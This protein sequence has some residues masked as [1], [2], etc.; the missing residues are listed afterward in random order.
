MVVQK[1][2]VC[3]E[4]CAVNLRKDVNYFDKKS[5]GSVVQWCVDLLHRGKLLYC[6]T[7]NCGN[8][9]LCSCCFLSA[10]L[11]NSA[12]GWAPL[13]SWW[14]ESCMMKSTLFSDLLFLT[15]TNISRCFWF[16]GC[17]FV[18]LT[19]LVLMWLPQRTT[20]QQML[21]A[22]QNRRTL[23]RSS[24]VHSTGLYFNSRSCPVHPTT[25]GGTA[26]K[27]S[28]KLRSTKST[29]IETDHHSSQGAILRYSHQ[30]LDMLPAGLRL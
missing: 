4:G 19:S 13:S 3:V 7:L 22:S 1:V 26:Q 25:A 6:V 16:N 14:E 10:E 30:T 15:H 20:A 28:E 12:G 23:K 29:G 21:L 27:S 2:T 8:D 11:N 24:C 18:L 5:S 17:L 9:L